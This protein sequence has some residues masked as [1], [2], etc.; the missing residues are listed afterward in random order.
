VKVSVLARVREVVPCRVLAAD[1]L[2]KATV[3]AATRLMQRLV[4]VGLERPG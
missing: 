4:E 1:P 3:D 2:G